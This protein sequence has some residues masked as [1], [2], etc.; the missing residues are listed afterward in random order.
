MNKQY[1]IS[2]D[3]LDEIT[4]DTLINV[5]QQTSKNITESESTSNWGDLKDAVA[6]KANLIGVI[7]YFTTEDMRKEK[8]LE[9]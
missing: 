3:V 1:T 2:G 4:V 5:Y 9:F 7:E 6:L 8:G